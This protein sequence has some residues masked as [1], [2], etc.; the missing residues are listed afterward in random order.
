M[1]RISRPCLR[2]PTWRFAK[3][4][5][6]VAGVPRPFDENLADKMRR[7]ARLALDL[8]LAVREKAIEVFFQPIH[9]A[10]DGPMIGV[11]ALAR[12]NHPALGPISPTEFIPLAEESGDILELGEWILRTSLRAARAWGDIFVSVNLSPLQFRLAELASTVA[13]ILSETRFPAARLQLEV[14]ESVLLHDLDTAKRRIEELHDIGVG[15]ALDDFGTGYSSLNYLADLP[16]DKIKIDRS[17]VR[18]AGRDDRRHAIIRH[19]V[20]L[21]RE[22]DMHVTA[23]GVETEEEAILLTAAGCTSLQGYYFGR[24]MPAREVRER[25][26]RKRAA[27]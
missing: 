3:Q 25:L 1:S 15:V 7:H 10:P 20:A 11:E 22:L 17:L 16:F 14:T 26:K 18:D 9:Q 13:S 21:A 2:T 12:W 23:E 19:I 24:P 8:A 6:P 5:N 4:S 27:A